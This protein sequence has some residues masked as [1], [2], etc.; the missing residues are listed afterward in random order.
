MNQIAKTRNRTAVPVLVWAVLAFV[1]ASALAR[2]DEVL[3]LDI[4][5][6]EAGPA[7]VKLAKSSGVQITLAG[8]AGTDV[9]VEGLQG[10]YRLDDALTTLLAGTGLTHEFASADQVLVRPAGE[11]AD[12]DDASGGKQKGEKG[13][14]ESRKKKIS[15]NWTSSA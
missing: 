12:E 7:L 11:A 4:P 6:Q 15:L 14:K 8:D 1:A 9:E 10:Q 13:Q 2:L 3:A 5:A